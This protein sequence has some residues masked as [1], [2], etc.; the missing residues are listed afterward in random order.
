MTKLLYQI[1]SYLREFEATITRVEGE[2]VYLDQTAFHPGPSGGL[3]TDTGWLILPDGTKL[4]VI[5]AVE[6]PND[7]AH[8]L[9]SPTVLTTGTKVKGIINWDRR[10]RMMRLHTA[11]HVLAAILYKKYGALVTG[12]HIQ[13]EGAR[14]DFDLTGV[15]DWKAALSEAISETNKILKSC[16][17]VKVYWLKRDEALK[18]PGIVKLANRLPPEVE[19]IR[20]VEIPGVDIQA[21]G[22]PHVKN[23]CEVGEIVLQKTE[24]KGA[25]RKRIYYTLTP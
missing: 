8:I 19:E 12:G 14:D 2:K 20:I 5:R 13:P 16:L 1:D 7:V 9:S 6:E 22:G 4:E 24:S 25:K 18:I 17:E 21:D 15:D 10:Y 3:D 11:S 23:T